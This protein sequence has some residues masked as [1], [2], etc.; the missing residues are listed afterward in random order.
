MGTQGS[1]VSAIAEPVSIM[2][3]SLRRKHG[4]LEGK[5]APET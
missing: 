5:E 3:V 1:A 4:Y 2:A